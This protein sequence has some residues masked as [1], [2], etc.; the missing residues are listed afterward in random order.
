MH[1]QLNVANPDF[2]VA[3]SGRLRSFRGV[4]YV[5]SLIPT[6]VSVADLQ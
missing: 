6:G 3:S 4:A 2:V 5:P 1:R